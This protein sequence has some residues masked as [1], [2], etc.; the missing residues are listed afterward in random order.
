MHIVVADR[1]SCYNNSVTKIVHMSR[2]VT[3][4]VRAGSTRLFAVVLVNSE[5]PHSLLAYH[6]TFTV[7]T[8]AKNGP[9]T[10]AIFLFRVC[11]HSHADFQAQVAQIVTAR[12]RCL[13]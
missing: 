2:D 9:K 12:I 6:S 1:V 8:V 4:L 13:C 7:A 5:S 11:T 10:K 3:K